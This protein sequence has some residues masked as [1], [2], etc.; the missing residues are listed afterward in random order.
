[1]LSGSEEHFI[2]VPDGDAGSIAT[3]HRMAG[4]IKL[5]DPWVDDFT[6]I[7]SQADRDPYDLAQ[8]VFEWVRSKMLYTPDRTDSDILDEIRTPGYLLRETLTFG[9]ALGDC[10]D[11][12]VLY[13][14]I[15]YRL[16]Y[17]VTL[18][19][20]SRHEDEMMDHVYLSIRIGGVRVAVDGIVDY[21]FA[22]EV[23]EEEITRRVSLPV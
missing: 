15:Y 14:A 6:D 10:D 3:L 21:P 22:W 4:L 19:A 11:Y 1:M 16:G 17:P 12:V 9:A 13:G 20:I 18:E 2:P 8:M 23:P 5:P 7:L